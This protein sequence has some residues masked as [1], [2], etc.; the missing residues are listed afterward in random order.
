MKQSNY[1]FQKSDIGA[2]SA[3]KG[4]SAQTLYIASRVINDQENFQ[5][6]P[7]D[8]EDLVVKY[9][10]NIVEAVQVKNISADLTLSTLA[11]TKTSASGD[12]FF[13]R[14]CSLHKQ[15]PSLKR[16]RVV[17]F[18]SLGTELDEF[19]RGVP[20]AKERIRRKLILNHDIVSDDAEWLLSAF[21]FDKCSLDELDKCIS[22]QTHSYLPT[23]AAP[24][25]AKSLLIQYISD[26]S[27]NKGYTSLHL[28]QEEIN[29]IGISI[30]AI[31][32]YFKEYGK[33]L[34]RLSD[35]STSMNSEQL[36]NEFMQ[37][38]SAHPAHI[39]EELDFRRNEWIAK[40]QAAL[41]NSGVALIKGVSGQGKTALCYRYLIDHYPEE[42][43]FCVRSI[44]TE[45]Q[46]YNLVSA[47]ESLSKHAPDIAVYID[48]LYGENQWVFLLQELQLRG[49]SVPVLISIRDE[50]YNLTQLNGKYV[51]FDIVELSLSEQ[52][53]RNIYDL[54][55][56]N[57][58]HPYHRSFEEAWQKFGTHG[59]LI[60]FM[61]LLTNNQT[62]TQRLIEQVNSLLLER[63]PDSWLTL[64][65]I[66][67]LTGRLGYSVNLQ[68]LRMAID[69]DNV[70][71]A[72][73]RFSDE[74]LIKISDNR[75]QIEA[76]HPVR[77]QI[78]FDA[79]NERIDN[80][81][82]DA[83][84]AS[85]NCI[86]SSGIRYILFDY[87]THNEYAQDFIHR[88]AAAHF[89]DWTAY[90]GTL[91]AMLW[92]DVKRYIDANMPFI[93]KLVKQ[94]GK[95]WPVFIP[96]DLTGLLC[97]NKL[98]AD[99]LINMPFADKTELQTAI[100]DVKTS[101]TTMCIDYQATDIFVSNCTL[102]ND[103]PK[104]DSEWACLGYSL[105]WLSK[106]NIT[107][108]NFLDINAFEKSM[109]IGDI[110]SR[111]DCLRGMIE[112]EAFADYY[113]AAKEILTLRIIKTYQVIFYEE[114]PDTLY[115]KF[116]PAMFGKRSD[117][118]E[119][120][121]HFNQYW[122]LKMVALLQ[123]LYPS[124]EYID[125]EL[126]GVDL[127]GDLGI[128]PLDY[129]LHIHKE[130]RKN[131]WVTD[132]NAWA[133]TR[134]DYCNRPNSWKEYVERIDCIRT[135]A[136]QLV[137]EIIGF[138]DFLYK[139]RRFNKD[140]WD[141]IVEKRKQFNAYTLGDNLLPKSV[142]DSYCLH[143]EDMFEDTAS[144]PQPHIACVRY[145]DKYKKF[146]KSYL[147]TFQPLDNFFQQ[148]EEVL[149]V[150]VCN[151]SI[152]GVKKPQLAMYNLFDSAK[153]IMEFQT[154]YQNLFPLYSTL[155][156]TFAAREVES[157]LVLVNM[158]SEVLANAPKG[159]PLS[160]EAKQRHRKSFD[161][162]NRVIPNFAKASEVGMFSN[163]D[164]VYLMFNFDLMGGTTLEQKYANAVMALREACKDAIPYSS[165]R[166]QIE[167]QAPDLVYV[168]LYHGVPL[169][170]G[171]SIPTYKLLD[172]AK[173]KNASSMLPV[174]ECADLYCQLGANVSGLTQW[175]K[176]I[177]QVGA[178]RLLLQQ[179][180]LVMTAPSTAIC[181]EGIEA[182]LSALSS[183]LEDIFNDFPD[184]SG[185]ID[186][187][188]QSPDKL[189]AGLL[190]MI[191]PFIKSIASIPEE[192]SSR[193]NL[194]GIEEMAN[195][196]AVALVL[197][198]PSVVNSATS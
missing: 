13:K 123:Q 141:R 116:V 35:L 146:R 148:C 157:L 142:A 190:S 154:E 92:I 180:N 64:L 38:V 107:V 198:Q 175:K 21:V 128:K 163:A 188:Q 96:I 55:A 47:L 195:K 30:A 63:I 27:R 2:Q 140:K 159:F 183:A 99:E 19:K 121:E 39:R 133:K 54:Y 169:S 28:W 139:K 184:V 118:G 46:A 37:G 73:K 97:P 1:S 29:R 7:E 135:I 122:R 52:E 31:D 82:E 43:V 144:E 89:F 45:I 76:L 170:S 131:G 6:F 106:R 34:I 181:E 25:M 160:Y 58:P 167:T 8:V 161:Y 147:K 61:Y 70:N 124:K 51:R 155:D 88:L 80:N 48:V 12:G 17:Y 57:Q 4:F 191:A 119:G 67:C 32:G 109:Y 24:D 172:T 102:P 10:N 125:I 120:T 85:I 137:I 22:K 115:C 166:W 111:A 81:Q 26:L 113:T 194:A 130:N 91:N 3:W 62:L 165:E 143:R 103:H 178:I 132:V 40:I 101:F 193:E 182:Y 179:Y 108:D 23:M 15:N 152:E 84:I 44:A 145:I 149:T 69:C 100:Q 156:T 60:E 98:I 112:H 78:I 177:S 187:L 18:N 5:F 150:R 71:A 174:G 104:L 68:G 114:T 33:S 72:I 16:V 49:L 134:I 50:D 196:A 11:S 129:K 117:D 93:Q 75:A 83:V 189:V 105:F 41:S 20:S 65:Q 176:A 126:L 87:F 36:R 185:I 197:L 110:Q 153:N 168:P 192:L 79:L 42:L 164:T 56:K 94:R 9:D 171:F 173:E 14:V 158:W 77:A 95:G 53:A 136:N 127:H 186:N 162:F 86:E 74:Y 90:A 59:P 151:K 66:I 138:I